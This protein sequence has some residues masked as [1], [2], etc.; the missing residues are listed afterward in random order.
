M[1]KITVCACFALISLSL[2][3]CST[4]EGVGKDMKSAGNAIQRT[5]E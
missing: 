1:K 5:F 4:M 2:G 3:A